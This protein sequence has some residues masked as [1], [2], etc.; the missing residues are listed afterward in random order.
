M[1]VV[2]YVAEQLKNASSRYLE[3]IVAHG[4]YNV[5]PKIKQGSSNEEYEAIAAEFER[6]ADEK[7]AELGRLP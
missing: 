7:L 6:Q 2:R 4:I 3:E 5:N 1:N